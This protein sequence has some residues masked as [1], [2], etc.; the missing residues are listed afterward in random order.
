MQEQN[1]ELSRT[2]QEKE[3]DV[4]EAKSKLAKMAKSWEEQLI[5]KQ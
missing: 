2:V 3:K 5:K 4:K 1:E